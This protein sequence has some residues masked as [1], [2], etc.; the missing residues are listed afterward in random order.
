MSCATER[1][2]EHFHLLWLLRL[3]LFGFGLQHVSSFYCLQRN[4]LPMQFLLHPSKVGSPARYRENMHPCGGLNCIIFRMC[5]SYRLTKSSGLHNDYPFCWLV[6]VGWDCEINT[7]K[8]AHSKQAALTTLMKVHAPLNVLEHNDETFIHHSR[9][10]SES[11][12][13]TR[14]D[15]EPTCKQDRDLNIYLTA[16]VWRHLSRCGVLTG[17]LISN[18]IVLGLL[19]GSAYVVYYFVERSEKRRAYDSNVFI[20]LL[21]RF[22]VRLSS[23]YFLQLST[24]VTLPTV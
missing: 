15:G 6:F 21:E 22:E 23:F 19:G 14:S 13:R 11:W 24:T 20:A 3:W 7:E 2:G 18:L 16:Y 5:K 12:K 9:K 1:S 17:R 8:G 4:F 10:K